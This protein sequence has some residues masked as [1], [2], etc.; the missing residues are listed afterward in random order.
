M[1]NTMIYEVIR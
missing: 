1:T